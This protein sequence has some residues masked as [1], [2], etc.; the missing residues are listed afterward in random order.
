VTTPDTN[1]LRIEFTAGND[2]ERAAVANAVADAVIN[3]FNQRVSLAHAK[4]LAAIDEALSEAKMKLTDWRRAHERLL[5]RVQ[6]NT[7]EKNGVMQEALLRQLAERR[8]KL[9]LDK[10]ALDARLAAFTDAT[11]SETAE[12]KEMTHARLQL[13]AELDQLEKLRDEE[14]AKK[15]ND[16]TWEHELSELEQLIA[17]MTMWKRTLTEKRDLAKLRAATSRIVFEKTQSAVAKP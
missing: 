4:R 13:V 7:P 6:A 8:A 5:R 17:D 16:L 12:F 10:V 11:G 2:V 9:L 1:S 15:A 14:F 3:E